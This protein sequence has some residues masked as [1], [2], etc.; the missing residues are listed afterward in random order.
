MKLA[1]YKYKGEQTP[2]F[3]FKKFNHIIDIKNCAKWLHEKQGDTSVIEI[4]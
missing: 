1:T 4:P 2:R 3:G